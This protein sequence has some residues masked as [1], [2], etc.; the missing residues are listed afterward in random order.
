MGIFAGIPRHQI[1]MPWIESTEKSLDDHVEGRE[2]GLSDRV[3]A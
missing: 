1:R 2:S 3:L